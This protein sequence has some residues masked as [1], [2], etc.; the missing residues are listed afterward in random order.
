[1]APSGTMWLFG[2]TA[3][4]HVRRTPMRITTFLNRTIG[5][6]GLWVK[7]MQFEKPL[8]KEGEVVVIEIRRR[9][10][11]LTCPE[12]GAQVRGRFE[13]KKRRWRH[14]GFWG[15]R[16]Y[17]EGPIRRLRCPECRAVRTEEV[18]W[19]RPGSWF[20]RA[21]E[22][23]VGLLAQ[24]LNHTAVAELT[25]ISW[26][27]VGSI[28]ERLVDENLH[29]DRFEDLRRIGVDEISYRKHHKYLTVV[30][31]HDRDRVIWVGEGKSS[32]TLA[33]FFEE[34]GPERTECLEQAS[35]DMS[36]GYEKCIRLYAPQAEIVFDRFHVARLANDAVTEVRREEARKLEPS[37]R[38]TLKGTR[39][40][41]L[42]R[43]QRLDAD[44]AAT[45]AGIKH[46]NTPVYRASLLKESFLDIFSTK[47]HQDAEQRLKEWLAW[48][49]RSRLKPFVRLGR[50][51]RKHFDG[52]LAFIDSR[53]TN[54]RLE[55]MNNKI[56]LLSHRAF[57]FHS[58]APLIAT[59][60]LC[61]SAIELP[62]L[63]VI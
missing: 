23:A 29:E 59:I 43:R 47:S 58:S 51:V 61:C 41:L 13:E 30:V 63:Q 26:A 25:G 22:D 37:E 24:Q 7:G 62:E 1:V 44:Q 34:L 27:T 40:I 4:V 21:F 53:L 45:L 33:M 17:L 42:K 35:I 38:A 39:W 15:H 32:E 56:R 10:Q 48:A 19:A 6:V 3:T 11:L 14:V 50:T 8:G 49:C 20:T 36:A 46:T 16:T 9:F 5:L 60:Y 2:K 52:I 54:A 55:G 12:C 31:D 28:A 18:P 57:G